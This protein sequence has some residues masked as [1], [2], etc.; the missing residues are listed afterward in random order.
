MGLERA[1]GEVGLHRKFPVPSID[2]DRQLDPSG[3]AI[4]MHHPEGSSNRP[5]GKEDIIHQHD[6]CAADIE[7]QLR[8]TKNRRFKTGIQIVSIEG[9]VDGAHLR[10]HS[11][12]LLDQVRQSFRERDTAL[13]YPDKSER[14]PRL[15]SVDDLRGE[16]TKTASYTVGIKHTTGSFVHGSSSGSAAAL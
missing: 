13:T 9:D 11:L 3:T 5:A 10:T 6:A 4:V 16:A 8:L 15:G 14:D 7:R 1:T 2:Q 12:V